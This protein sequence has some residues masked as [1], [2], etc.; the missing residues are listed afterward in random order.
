[1]KK[2]RAYNQLGLWL[3]QELN[4]RNL[5]KSEFAVLIDTTPQNMSDILRGHRFARDTLHKWEIKCRKVFRDLDE[6]QNADTHHSISYQI[7][8]THV[9]IEGN[10]YL[11]YGLQ[12]LD[13]RTI[14]DEVPDISV[15]PHEV[16]DMAEQ[17]TTGKAAQIHFRDLVFDRVYDSHT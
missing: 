6:A 9:E 10:R 4:K 2:T 7:I 16:A 14:L 13:S 11:T 15:R 3:S 17:F 5:S 8:C 1:M 12:M